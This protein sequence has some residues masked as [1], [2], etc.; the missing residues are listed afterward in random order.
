MVL[1]R[2][3]V[4]A[5]MIINNR[6]QLIDQLGEG[7]TGVVYTAL[8]R[9]T[10][11]TVALKRMRVAAADLRFASYQAGGESGTNDLA[12]AFEFRTLAALR[13]PH[14]VSVLDYGFDQQ[15]QPFLT[16]QLIDGARMITE[17]G[18]DCDT[19]TKV[20][21]LLEMLQALLYLHRRHIIHRDIKPSNVLVTADGTIKVMDF[22]LAVSRS[23]SISTNQEGLAGTL[24][25]MAPELFEGREATIQS[26]LFA[27][28]LIAYELLVGR[29]PFDDQNTAAVLYSIMVNTPD[30]TM[31]PPPFAAV[32]NTLLAKK[33]QERYAHAQA[34]IE[35]I[36]EATDQPLPAESISVRESF[37]QASDFVGRERELSILKRALENI[38][39]DQPAGS[40][41]LI[42]GESGVG[43]SRLVDEL[44]IR[45]LIR[46][47]LVLYGQGVAEGG[48]PYQLWRSPVRRLV[49]SSQL[50]D[51]DT[52]I[53]KELVP[54]IGELLSRAIPDIPVLNGD[55][56][57]QRMISTITRLF[58][59]QRQPVV[60]ILEDLQWMAESLEPLKALHTMAADLPLL[61][62]GNYRDDEA[63][64]LPDSLPGMQVLKLERLTEEAIEALTV[65]MLG[66]SGRQPELTNLLKRET[67][68]NA[69]FIV[70]VMRILAED[71]GRLSNVGRRTLPESVFSGGIKAVIR[72]RLDAVPEWARRLL[73]LTAVAG[74]QLDLT[75][76]SSLSPDLETWLNDCAAAAVLEIKDGQWRFSHDKLREA[77]IAD[78][79][80][81]ERPELHRQVAEAIETVYPQD[82]TWVAVLLD[83]WRQAGD[84]NREIFYA[85]Q[86]VERFL[87]VS[88]FREV[89]DTA[90]R[91]L[92]LLADIG[93][94]AALRAS[95]GEAYHKLGMIDMALQTFNESLSLANQVGD[96]STA[97][98]CYENLGNVALRQG[99]FATARQNFQ[100]SLELASQVQDLGMIGRSLDSL[101]DVL[102]S[103]G[104]FGQARDYYERSLAVH[105][106]IDDK[107]GIVGNLNGLG[108]VASSQSNYTLSRR[109]FEQSLAVA[110]EIGERRMIAVTLGNLGAIA[111][112]QGDYTTALDYYGQNLQ[113][114]R[115][116]GHKSGVAWALWAI[117]R[118]HVLQGDYP[119]ADDLNRQSLV[120]FREL[121]DRVYMVANLRVFGQLAY[122]Q[123]DYLAA[124]HY[125]ADSLRMSE[126][127]G[128]QLGITSA[129]VCLGRT[130][131]ARGDFTAAQDYFERCLRLTRELDYK[132]T[133]A[134]SLCGLGNIAIVRGDYETARDL[135]GESLAITRQIS[136]RD[137]MADSLLSLGLFDRLQGDLDSAASRYQEV[138]VL[139]RQIGLKA[140]IAEALVSR[141]FVSLESSDPSRALPDLT[142]GLRL[143]HQIGLYPVVLK[144]LLG[145]A[146]VYWMQSAL[147]R[148]AELVKLV[149]S[150]PALDALTRHFDLK[151]LQDCLAAVQW[152]DVPALSF[153]TALQQVMSPPVQ[154]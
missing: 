20:R 100:Q 28:G 26:D 148:C 55:E 57:Q 59:Q 137:G 25:Y 34:V 124:Q 131:S 134:E 19:A 154:G 33:P 52:A 51:T 119:A 31:L 64:H 38:L 95:L 116:T 36:C 60:L 14:I 50:D 144:G 12:L 120:M 85:K 71:A 16:M 91:T 130:S 6:Y 67:E 151:P 109:R 17:Y 125:H 42:G 69:F 141:A 53:L 143:A 41:W 61:I 56:S 27:I 110:H 4:A 153:D 18:A 32:L 45:A 138:L 24:A 112:A 142:D 123:G 90:L 72:R 118:I 30:T 3:K 76:L 10:G 139:S 99:D 135:L 150:H 84:H 73:K 133:I 39:S 47:A 102:A 70:E 22:G 5:Y 77:L 87:A 88:S 111:T 92:P 54:D 1:A 43:K 105:Q 2:E 122:L 128:Q 108:W 8:D 44:R 104:D 136:D 11:E 80:P 9:L 89:V 97:A 149:R 106:Q 121:G 63:P 132:N 23:H 65:S 101:G 83:H 117:A 49:L 94:Q 74:R 62:I 29:Y 113:I 98:L 81:E 40:A 68:G 75:V 103:Q 82:V 114:S 7:G 107:R 140:R 13:H 15:R 37:L 96:P 129:L 66:E 146:R 78:L 126:E 46:G 58:W 79:T 145:F 93:E 35:A 115:E 86:A 21:L 48:L 152:D 127:V 147:P